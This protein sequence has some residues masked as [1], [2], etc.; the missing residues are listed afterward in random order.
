MLHGSKLQERLGGRWELGPPAPSHV[1]L[2]RSLWII[3][4][5]H[6][7]AQVETPG[8]ENPAVT[9][10]FETFVFHPLTGAKQKETETE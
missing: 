7:Q 5:R 10:S 4:L 8:G 6:C 3:L 9:M 1:A 2:L